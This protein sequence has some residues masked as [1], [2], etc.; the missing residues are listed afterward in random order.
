[1]SKE[2]LKKIQNSIDLANEDLNNAEGH[3][4]SVS[5][6]LT[7]ELNTFDDVYRIYS[8]QVGSQSQS[9]KRDVQGK[10]TN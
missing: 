5:E 3:Y 6:T 8:S 9:Y 4:K 7:E 2:R 1:M 10:I